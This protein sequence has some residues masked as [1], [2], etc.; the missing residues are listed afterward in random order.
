MY[1]FQH[2]KASFINIINIINISNV[3]S[4]I[5]SIHYSNQYA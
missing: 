2:K 4:G 1:L 3:T 5:Y